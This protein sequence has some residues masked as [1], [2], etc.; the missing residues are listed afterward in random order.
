MGDA[1]EGVCVGVGSASFLVLKH[2]Q[3][4]K[5]RAMHSL[6]AASPPAA[7]AAAISALDSSRQA[8]T[9]A[10]APSC[11]LSA[12]TASNSGFVDGLQTAL[13]A[14]QSARWR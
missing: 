1:E 2:F 3:P 4:A 7:A 14:G 10:R 12:R 11:M 5:I 13:C 8:M 6:A 9:R